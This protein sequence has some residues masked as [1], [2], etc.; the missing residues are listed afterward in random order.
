M[1]CEECRAAAWGSEPKFIVKNV[2]KASGGVPCGCEVHRLSEHSPGLVRDEELL[3][4]LVTYPQHILP[5]GHV[6]PALLVSVDVNG[7][8]VLRGDASDDEF[9]ITLKMLRDGARRKNGGEL[10]L[11]GVFSFNASVIRYVAGDRLVCVLD[12]AMQDRPH[13]A[14]IMGP[15]VLRND[16][17]TLSKNQTKKR[18]MARIRDILD[19]IGP[20]MI[21]AKEFRDS[22]LAEFFA[23]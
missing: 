6:H 2:N 18:Q 1:T 19:L 7:Q 11:H 4:L 13:H 12:T 21:S 5:D 3:N 10:Y 14:D 22:A 16:E 8:S 20:T 9:K 23:S 17:E 15:S